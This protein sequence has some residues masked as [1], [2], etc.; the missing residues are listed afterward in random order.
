MDIHFKTYL[1]SLRQPNL[2][3]MQMF[4]WLFDYFISKM[5]NWCA[6]NV[7]DEHYRPSL[8]TVCYVSGINSFFMFFVFM[9]GN[10]DI[11]SILQ[12]TCCINI[13]FQV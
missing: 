2:T 9:L 6:I 1:A 12:C 13:C 10:K 4:G 7:F 3:P 8:L 11:V 5:G